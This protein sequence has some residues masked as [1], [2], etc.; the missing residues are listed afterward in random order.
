MGT[1]EVRVT[2]TVKEN[3]GGDDDDDEFAVPLFQEW[4]FR[5]RSSVGGRSQVVGRRSQVAV[6]SR[7]LFVCVSGISIRND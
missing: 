1:V 7:R 6:R 3:G 5:R 4:R 2:M